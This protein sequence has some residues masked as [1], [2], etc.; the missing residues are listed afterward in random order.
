MENVTSSQVYRGSMEEKMRAAGVKVPWMAVSRGMSAGRK[1]LRIRGL[2][3]RMAEG[4]FKVLP[5][6][7]QHFQDLGKTQTLYRS[8]G[9]RDLETGEML[10]DGELVA[11]FLRFRWGG[12]GTY[13]VDIPDALADLEA[14]DK[15]GRRLCY[16]TRKPNDER[17][18]WSVPGRAIRRVPESFGRNK[19]AQGGS[20]WSR[21]RARV[22]A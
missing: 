21:V 13:A 9:Y 3:K 2:T 22:K 5:T 18:T 16:M 10:P 14:T 6:V 12:G 20:Y 17:A 11:Q 7:P 4:R 19:P 15:S 8:D 1:D